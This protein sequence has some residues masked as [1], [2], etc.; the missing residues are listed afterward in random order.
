MRFDPDQAQFNK[1]PQL[2]AVLLEGK[3]ESDFK[4]RIT[5]Q[6]RNANAIAF[7]DESKTTAMVVVSD[8]DITKN[9]VNP[10]TEEYLPLGVD[11]YTKQEYGNADFMLNVV[12]Y[13][14]DDSGLM[15]IR[16]KNLKIRLL[17]ETLIKEDRL[18]WELINTLIPIIFI[19]LF[20]F[21][22]FIIRKRKYTH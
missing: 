2:A 13:L 5:P 10:K 17:D 19:A 3:F 18:K 14:C 1:G 8:G 12:N 20:G 6:I 7:K 21:I 4:N 22:F 9:V 11:K 16:N 15:S